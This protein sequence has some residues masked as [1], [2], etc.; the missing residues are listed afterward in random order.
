MKLSLFTFIVSTLL[1]IASCDEQDNNNIQ[2]DLDKIPVRDFFRSPNKSSYKISPDGMRL[3]YLSKKNNRLNIF[4]QDII[5]DSAIVITN[6]SERDIRAYVWANNDKIL[7]VKD[8]N[9]NEQYQLY[10]VNIDGS[11]IRRLTFDTASTIGIIDALPEN[12]SEI[13]IISNKRDKTLFDPYRLNIET[14]EMKILAENPGNIQSWMTDHDGKLR[15]AVA[16]DM[17]QTK[18]LYRDD[19]SQDFRTILT[20]NSTDN[21]APSFFTFDNRNLYAISNI[22]RDKDAVVEIDLESGKELRTLYENPNSDVMSVYGSPARKVLTTAVYYSWK[23][24]AFFFDDSIKNVVHSIE[25]MLPGY[26]IS[27]S[28]VDEAENK[29]IVRTFSDRSLGAYYL[30]NLEEKSLKMLCE[31]SP[32]LNE[33][34]LAGMKPIEYPARDGITIHGYITYPKGK[35]RS[36]LPLVVMPHGGPWSR[37]SWG[38]DPEAQF[39]AN[40]G[41]A[42]L[43]MNFRGS[44]GYG[45]KFWE[46]SFKQWGLKMQDDIAD[47]VQWLIN[48]GEVDSNRIAIYGASY[49]GYAA[50]MGAIK[51]PNL[52]CCAIDYAGLSNLFTYLKSHPPYWKP[53]I[54]KLYKMIGDPN[55]DSLQLRATSPFYNMDKIVIPLFVAH[56]ANDNKVSR[57]ETDIFVENLKKRGIEVEYM[58][59]ENEGHGFRNEENK[60]DF[61]IQMEKFLAKHMK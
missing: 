60:F 10:A 38:F 44:I 4:V 15:L 29:Y 1:L 49:G 33:N 59:K 21:L 56:G 35:K 50:L 20:T 52:Y 2:L 18:I 46:A 31:V 24:E 23:S 55:K 58:L 41:Y 14:G 27:I 6:E 47:G 39:L 5:T 28:S 25:K 7:F 34:E 61:Y 11:G 53:F 9:G 57:N 42:V 48:K 3:A 51:T 17:A 37:D 12:E 36:K 54:K 19:E 40:R 26:E 45:K 32:W 22:G 8:D 13:I 43:Q 30:Y 16:T